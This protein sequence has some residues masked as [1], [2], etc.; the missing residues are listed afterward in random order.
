MKNSIREIWQSKVM[1]QRREWHLK[2]KKNNITLCQDCN[3]WDEG[4]GEQ[5]ISPEYA[6]KVSISQTA[7]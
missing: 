4:T 3:V 7:I 1:N 6:E 5:L 2:N